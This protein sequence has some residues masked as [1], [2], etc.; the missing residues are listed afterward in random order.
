MASATAFAA[1]KPRRT[2]CSGMP[3]WMRRI[4]QR[5]SPID[6]ETTAHIAAF[7]PMRYALGACPQK[8]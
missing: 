8:M 4:A 1:R 5:V 6:A 2:A 3:P 7:R